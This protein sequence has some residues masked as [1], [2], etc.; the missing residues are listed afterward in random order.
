[1]IK[2]GLILTVL[3][4]GT[5][6]GQ[7][8]SEERAQLIDSVEDRPPALPPADVRANQV[9]QNIN[10]VRQELTAGIQA[11]LGLLDGQTRRRDPFGMAA[12]LVE[13][14]DAAAEATTQVQPQVSPFVSALQRIQ[15]DGI[16]PSEREFFVGPR[17]IYEGDTLTFSHDG[18]RFK[19]LVTKVSPYRIVMTDSA[20][21]E[22]AV[23]RLNIIPQEVL[24]AN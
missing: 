20:T 15:V 4:A 24:D 9:Q 8:S 23:I 2:T 14:E 10:L 12:N 18:R 21:G 16:D 19:A 5:V 17:N 1:M 11:T 13:Q 3:F 22:T 7:M 6:F